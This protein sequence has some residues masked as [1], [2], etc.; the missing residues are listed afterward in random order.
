MGAYPYP[1]IVPGPA[2]QPNASSGPPAARVLRDR[3]PGDKTIF[4]AAVVNPAIATHFIQGRFEPEWGVPGDFVPNRGVP[5]AGAGGVRPDAQ[6][7]APGAFKSRAAPPEAIRGPNASTQKVPWIKAYR[8]PVNLHD[9][10]QWVNLLFFNRPMAR[11]GADT[12][13]PGVPAQYFTPPP[14]ET[15][16]L[17]A[18]KLNLQLRLGQLKI[19]A[20]ALTMAASNYFG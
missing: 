3:V 7:G 9:A 2:A 5:P 20:A 12:S 6:T 16:N 14:V 1:T 13:N 19:Q 18:G 10:S 4:G 17:G 8:P 11:C 15:D